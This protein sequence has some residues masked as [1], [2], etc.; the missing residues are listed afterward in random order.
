MAVPCLDATKPTPDRPDL[1]PARAHDCRSADRDQH[2][3]NQHLGVSRGRRH[4]RRQQRSAGNALL[5]FWRGYA[6]AASRARPK[7]RFDATR[8]LS[9]G[10]RLGPGIRHGCEASVRERGPA[11]SRTSGSRSA[12]AS[13]RLSEH[14][15]HSGWGVGRLECAEGLGD[16]LAGDEIAGNQ[17]AHRAVARVGE[18]AR[19][20][21][22]ASLITWTRRESPLLIDADTCSAWA[23]QR[24]RQADP[25]YCSSVGGA[26][27]RRNDSLGVTGPCILAVAGGCFIA[28]P[29]TRLGG[30]TSVGDGN[31]CIDARTFRRRRRRRRG[32]P[33][34][35]RT[36]R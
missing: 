35:C 32:P 19:A 25:R 13:Q 15:N 23:K 34:S 27:R 28:A 20:A 21:T 6:D 29:V 4:G 24:R 8:G 12:V 3:A 36:A 11:R 5:L 1:I 7:P 16:V 10:N 26:T 30:V 22:V 33:P 17:Q 18:Q 14:D 9:P 31:Q 2:N